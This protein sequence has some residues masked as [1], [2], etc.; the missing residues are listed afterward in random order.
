MT[1]ELHL[2]IFR[3][4]GFAG[5]CGEICNTDTRTFMNETWITVWKQQKKN[6]R[7]R[8]AGL[9]WHPRTPPN[10]RT[11]NTE[12]GVVISLPITQQRGR[13]V[14]P[15]IPKMNKQDNRQQSCLRALAADESLEAEAGELLTHNYPLIATADS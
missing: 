8:F 11:G 9:Y 1:M 2:I 4:M 10:C 3:L 14:V 6:N 7:A 15:L 5:Q 12:E 13:L